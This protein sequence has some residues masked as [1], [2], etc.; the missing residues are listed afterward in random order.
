MVRALGCMADGVLDGVGAPYLS[1]AGGSLRHQA[2]FHELAPSHRHGCLMPHCRPTQLLDFPTCRPVYVSA[3]LPSLAS[4]LQDMGAW[5]PPETRTATSKF[6]FANAE[7]LVSPASSWIGF[8]SQA[9]MAPMG[10]AWQVRGMRFPCQKAAVMQNGAALNTQGCVVPC[11]RV[12]PIPLQVL[13]WHVC[14][15]CA[16]ALCRA[17]IACLSSSLICQRIQKRWAHGLF[18]LLTALTTI[19]TDGEG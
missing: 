3:A 4:R 6:S 18:L 10:R 5:Q 9:S 11:S 16:L 19:A 14:L 15:V 8:K 17:C 7:G 12:Q 13:N 1:S 2:G